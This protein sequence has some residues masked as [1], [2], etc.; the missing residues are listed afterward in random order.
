MNFWL[1]GA[2]T[3]WRGGKRPYRPHGLGSASDVPSHAPIA[4]LR[5]TVG[6]TQQ[7]G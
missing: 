2:N 3:T 4:T 6:K 1:Y 7:I 5:P